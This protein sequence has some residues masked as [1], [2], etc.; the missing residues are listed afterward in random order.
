MIQENDCIWYDEEKGQVSIDCPFVK[1]GSFERCEYCPAP[2]KRIETNLDG[3]SG[4]IIYTGD[5]GLE[6]FKPFIS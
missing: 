2:H 3:K 1:A 5:K 6:L 4:V